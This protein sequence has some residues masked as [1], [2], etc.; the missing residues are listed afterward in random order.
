V[1]ET[2]D[3]II[4]LSINVTL[5]KNSGFNVQAGDSA[6]SPGLLPYGCNGFGQ[7]NADLFKQILG[8]IIAAYPSQPISLCIN[9]PKTAGDILLDSACAGGNGGGTVAPAV[10]VAPL[11]PKKAPLKKT[12]P[13]AGSRRKGPKK[14]G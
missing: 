11:A 13:K 5:G 3:K 14:P 7:I 10:A 12:A 1:T 6:T 4:F 9:D 8:K 2:N